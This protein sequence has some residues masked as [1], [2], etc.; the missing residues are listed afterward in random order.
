M[1]LVKEGVEILSFWVICM[2]KSD[3]WVLFFK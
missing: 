3:F 2:V 1:V